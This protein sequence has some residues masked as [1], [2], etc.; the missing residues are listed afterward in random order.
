MKL[1]TATERSATADSLLLVTRE[2][3]KSIEHWLWLRSYLKT[4]KAAESLKRNICE[5]ETQ[6]RNS[7]AITTF[8]YNDYG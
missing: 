5:R 3:L 1:L 4:M 8:G 7:A 6:L 2:T